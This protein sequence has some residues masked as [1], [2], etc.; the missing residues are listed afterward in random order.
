M[1]S[2]FYIYSVLVLNLDVKQDMELRQKAW[3]QELEELTDIF[4]RLCKCRRK[5][6]E[7]ENEYLAVDVA[8]KQVEMLKRVSL[9]SIT[10]ICS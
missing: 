3:Q 8:I 6:L 9:D 1:L 10:H 2:C 4:R 5:K 7:K